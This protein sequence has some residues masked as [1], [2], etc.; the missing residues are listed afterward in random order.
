VWIAVYALLSVKE[1]SNKARVYLIDGWL[2]RGVSTVT[3]LSVTDASRK[4]GVSRRTLYEQISCGEIKRTSSGIELDELIRVYPQLA[5]PSTQQPDVQGKHEPETVPKL[6]KIVEPHEVSVEKTIQQAGTVE[7]LVRELEWNK[8]LLEQTN[9]A[10]ARQLAEQ[11]ALIA[12]QAR[13]LDEKDRFWARQVE[14]AQSLL[15]APAPAPRK[16]FLGIF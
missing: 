11:R 14:I 4:V 9:Q 2:Q 13:R 10:M 1:K 16:K 12:D 3:T 7:L 5:Q 6:T 15:P 8:E